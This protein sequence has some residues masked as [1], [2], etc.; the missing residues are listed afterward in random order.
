MYVN[1]F[2]YL[3]SKNQANTTINMMHNFCTKHGK[4]IEICKQ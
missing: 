4:I 2:S 1:Y 3:Y